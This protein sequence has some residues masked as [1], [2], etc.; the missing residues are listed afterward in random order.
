MSAARWKLGRADDGEIDGLTFVE[1]NWAIDLQRREWLY[2][3]REQLEDLARLAAEEERAKIIED[4]NAQSDARWDRYKGRDGQGQ[5]SA[6]DLDQGAS[7][8]LEIAAERC[9]AGEHWKRKG[10]NEGGMP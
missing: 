9:L 6:S 4:L 3:T 10:D 8:A 2:L 5:G 1:D 7:A